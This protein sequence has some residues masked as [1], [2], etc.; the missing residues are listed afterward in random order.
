MV[1]NESSDAGEH[2]A[3][4]YRRAADETLHQL[5]WCITY[6]YRIRKPQI[7][8]ALEKNRS[9]IRRQLTEAQD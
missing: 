5:E 1:S 9:M 4:R 6:L 2:E 7:A 8:E 3:A